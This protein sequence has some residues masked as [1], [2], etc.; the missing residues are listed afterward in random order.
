MPS[1]DLEWSPGLSY[2]QTYGAPTN[3]N[4]TTSRNR[5]GLVWDDNGNLDSY[6]TA[7]YRWTWV[8]GWRGW[9]PA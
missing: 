5:T 7:D 2:A 4:Q 8:A 9:K 3:L 6:G 1:P